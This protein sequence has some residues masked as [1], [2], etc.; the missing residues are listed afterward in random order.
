LVISHSEG[1]ETA[2]TDLGSQM[3][4]Y[5]PVI[6][7]I[8]P[9]SGPVGTYMK[10]EGQ[11]FYN[12]GSV[13]FTGGVT[14]EVI[15]WTDTAIYC[16]VPNGVQTGN[17]IV[18]CP[19][20]DSNVKL[21]TAT[22]PVTIFVDDDHT[23]EIENGTLTYPFSTIQ[24][25]INAATT[26]DEIIVAN[27]TYHENINFNG[28]NIT[29]TSTNPYDSDIVAATII[30][31]SQNGTVVTFSNGED[32]NCT[33]TGFTITNG[34]AYN[35]GGIYCDGSSPTIANCIIKNNSVEWN[36]GGGIKCSNA[37]DPII[38][39]CIIT[40]NS[41]ENDGEGGGIYCEYDSSPEITNCIIANNSSHYNGGGIYCTDSSNP[42][43]TSCVIANNISEEGYGGGIFSWEGNNILVRNCDIVGNIAGINGG[44][45]FCAHSEPKILGNTI[46]GCFAGFGGGIYSYDSSIVVSDNYLSGNVAVY[47]GGGIFSTGANPVIKNN[48]I[49]YNYHSG[50]YAYDTTIEVKNNT[51][52]GN[53]G[54]LS[55]GIACDANS[56][57]TIENNTIV[58]NWGRDSGGLGLDVGSEAYVS[59]CILWDNFTDSNDTQIAL[60]YDEHFAK[61]TVL[62][63]NHSNVEYDQSNVYLQDENCLLTWGGNNISMNPQF[64]SNGIWDSNDI[65]WEGD[66]H[67]SSD[68]PC[69]DAGDPNN[70]EDINEF[71]ID[72][73]SRIIGGRIDIGADEYT[74]GDLS[75]FSDNGIVNFGDFAILAY[76]W[77]EYVCEE[78]DWCEGCDFDRSER[79]DFVDLR[80]FGENWLWQAAWYNE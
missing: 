23:P 7:S 61:Q 58:E 67:L 27:G 62:D 78:P 17:I 51:I 24:R 71:D 4:N 50:I 74:F 28:K 21:F 44:G 3:T 66:Y 26:S 5:A 75:D 65:W 46:S 41:A 60:F 13:I 20:S 43:I 55:G 56:V 16:K 72:G 42:T 68:S 45:L 2:W 48:Y 36:G 63:I 54:F 25:G 80:R 37:S 35:G 22:D 59:N 79:V 77:Q 31:G 69:I 32:T 52:A 9:D 19:N 76:Y 38:K 10:I 1:V 64:I 29:V 40:D 8:T 18:N 6:T 15:Q 70:P 39:D 11:H 47:G 73:D 30:D 14:G 53:E 49:T 12:S 34:Y 57:A 33:L